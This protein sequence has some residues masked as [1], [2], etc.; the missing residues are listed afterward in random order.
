MILIVVVVN[1]TRAMFQKHLLLVLGMCTVL[2]KVDST[3]SFTSK[4]QEI[5]LNNVPPFGLGEGRRVGKVKGRAISFSRSELTLA[6]SLDCVLSCLYQKSVLKVVFFVQV[7]GDQSVNNVLV[8]CREGED[9][10]AVAS[11]NNLRDSSFP[12]RLRSVENKKRSNV[13]FCPVDDISSCE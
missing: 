4:I 2:L 3:L 12:F 1:I 13:I 9:L 7:G 10:N 8:R 11:F 5:I 6:S